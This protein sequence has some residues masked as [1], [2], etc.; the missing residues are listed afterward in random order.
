MS[1]LE[2][3]LLCVWDILNATGSTIESDLLEELESAVPRHTGVDQG[4]YQRPDRR[5]DGRQEG[6]RI[7]PG[8]RRRRSVIRYGDK[9]VPLACHISLCA[10][11][12]ARRRAEIGPGDD[13]VGAESGVVATI[14]VVWVYM[15]DLV[16]SFCQCAGGGERGKKVKERTD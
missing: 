8:G 4:G 1:V 12:L 7:L 5:D 16:P 13:L 3:I 15:N 9:S 2:H 14:V 11:V 6:Y 10:L